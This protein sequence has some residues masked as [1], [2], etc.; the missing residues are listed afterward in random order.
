MSSSTTAPKTEPLTE[1]LKGLSAFAAKVLDQLSLTAWL[2]AAL[3]SATLALLL[4]FRTQNSVNLQT[5]LD[6][7]QKNWIAV[8][9][10]AVP[11][12]VLTTLTTQAFSFTAIQ[13]LEGYGMRRRPLRWLRD[14]MTWH[15]VRRLNSLRERKRRYGGRAFDRSEGEWANEPA[16]I[17]LA[18]RAAAHELADVTLPTEEMREHYAGLDWRTM[19]E[20]WDLARWDDVR[21]SIDECPTRARIL[22]TKLGNVLRST[23]DFVIAGTDEDLATFA[24]RRR[25]LL[26]PLAQRQHDQF[27]DR[28]DMYCTLVFVCAALAVAA[29]LLSYNRCLLRGPFVVIAVGFVLLAIVSY[30]AAV[31]SARGYCT[32]L[33]LMKEVAPDLS[34]S[35]PASQAPPAAARIRRRYGWLRS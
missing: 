34:A 27:R 10:L 35:A 30:S 7:I 3:V 24:I 19:C 12:L 11:V 23:E 28:L 18:L 20:P 2:P 25:P 15:Q 17:V 21:G 32:Q 31:T 6:A 8:L 22:P 16:E 14:L 26:D 1:E 5:A 13:F 29:P 33:R 9:L 4:Q